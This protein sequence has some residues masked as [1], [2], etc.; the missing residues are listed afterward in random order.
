MINKSINESYYNN[1]C[2]SSSE[3]I[4]THFMLTFFFSCSQK[5]VVPLSHNSVLS[6][7]DY[8]SVFSNIQVRRG[9]RRR[10]GGRRG[11]RRRGGEEGGGE[12][13]RGRGR[14]G[15]EGEVKGEGKLNLQI[16]CR[17]RHTGG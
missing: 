3:N 17:V 15:E 9:G 12:R 7:E 6:H 14:M 16:R 4:F 11:G 10:G 8:S 1:L 2:T 5:F 13:G